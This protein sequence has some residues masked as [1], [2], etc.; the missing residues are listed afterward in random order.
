MGGHRQA[1]TAAAVELASVAPTPAPAASQSAPVT[2]SCRPTAPCAPLPSP[3]PAPT[4][5]EVLEASRA[6]VVGIFRGH[7]LWKALGQKVVSQEVPHA[8]AVPHRV[9]GTGKAALTATA[10]AAAAAAA[11]AGCCCISGGGGSCG[12]VQ[13]P[14]AFGVLEAQDL[15]V[16]WGCGVRFRYCFC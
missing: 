1:C 11:L 3:L 15:G 14:L 4:S 2:D 13:A 8:L 12:A 5:K 6:H 16:A 9:V 10:A 7:R